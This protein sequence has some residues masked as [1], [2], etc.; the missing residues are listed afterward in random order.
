MGIRIAI[1]SAAAVL[2]FGCKSDKESEDTP[3]SPESAAKSAQNAPKEVTEKPKHAS[4]IQWLEDDYAGA[5]AAAKKANKP[6]VVDMWAPWCHTCLSMKSTVL[7]DAGLAGHADRFVWVGLDTDK[8]VNAPALKDLPVTAWPT[9]FVLA[10]D[11]TIAGRFLGSASVNQF[12]EF[13]DQGEKAARAGDDALVKDSA[14]WHLR[15]ADRFAVGGKMSEAA[16][17]YGASLA[18]AHKDWPR[19]ADVLVSHISALYKV[20]KK[21][22]A[23]LATRIGETVAARSASTPDFAYYATSC[24]AEVQGE[25]ASNAVRTD[26]IKA[27]DAVLG[28]D[29]ANLSDDDRSDALRIIREQYEALGDKENARKRAGEQL[30][31]L[32]AA[33]KAS[34]TPF[35]AMTYNWPRSEVYVYLGRGEEL[36]AD[37][38]K[39]ALDLPNEYDPPYRLAWVLHKLDKNDEALIEVAKAEAL[40]YGPR[41]G[42][43]LTLKADV[44]ATKSSKPE[45]IAAHE[46]VL[47]H[48]KGLAAGHRS[49]AAIERA[50]D[51]L[52]AAKK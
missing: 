18:A 17:A 45:T 25:K 21:A 40:A 39:S 37:L 38:R 42:R 22:C 33:A 32:N 6:L 35:A 43:V 2:A 29:A 19:R 48:Y 20:D 46:A 12:R 10:P 28:D 4:G 16:A 13:L 31:L 52:A 27:I 44:L 14:E 41:K 24:A 50:K 7:L 36:L 9:F 8:E 5:L 15:E 1:A 49:D 34:D 26:S 47:A 11:G 51:A 3:T 23:K 30:E